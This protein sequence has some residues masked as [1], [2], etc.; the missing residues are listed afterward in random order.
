MQTYYNV[1]G[2]KIVSDLLAS[3]DT[4][5]ANAFIKA[6]QDADFQKGVDSLGRLE[7]A[8]QVGNWDSVNTHLNAILSNAGYINPANHEVS[9]TPIIDHATG[10]A[11]G[12]T[13]NYKDKN[14]GEEVTKNFNSMAD[15][16][17]SLHSLINPQAAVAYNQSL[18][19]AQAA[20]A[21][22]T[23]QGLED[24][25]NKIA[26]D[27]AAK[28]NDIKVNTAKAALP[29]SIKDREAG[30]A[31]WYSNIENGSGFP[32]VKGP[33][34]KDIEMTEPQKQRMAADQ[35][36]AS[37]VTAGAAPSTSPFGQGAPILASRPASL[38][39][40]SAPASPDDV[41]S[42]K[43]RQFLQSRG[44][45]M[46]WWPAQQPA[47]PGAPVARGILD[48]QGPPKPPGPGS[49]NSYETRN[50]LA[51]IPD[52]PYAAPEVL[53]HPMAGPAPAGGEGVDAYEQRL[54]L[55]ATPP[56]RPPVVI[57]QT[58]QGRSLA[59]Y[60]A[61][62]K[63]SAADQIAQDAKKRRLTAAQRGW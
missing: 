35:Y 32:T 53:R 52:V 4:A 24:T 41:I 47:A 29:E 58:P 60:E 25:K 13:V 5:G 40:A 21:A 55:A 2:P 26:I 11:T 38:P 1:G 59:D 20:S 42:Q 34:G 30:I 46:P 15:L 3:G 61:S 7:G 23:A 57:S 44:I 51:N 62:L 63:P 17:N 28:A 45:Q 31:K 9:A 14:T 16:H 54:G 19:D 22:K 6:H 39:T 43:S 12:L 10:K 49:V 18:I 33:D 37:R 48:A 50:N 27:D 36:D 56:P 8:A